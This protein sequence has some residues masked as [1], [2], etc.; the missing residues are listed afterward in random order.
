MAFLCLFV[1]CH[2]AGKMTGFFCSCLLVGIPT[3]ETWRQRC[4]I[5]RL[6]FLFLLDSSF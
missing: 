1:S 3:S 5:V 4:V 2:R 6:F